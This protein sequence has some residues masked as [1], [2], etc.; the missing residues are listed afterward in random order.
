MGAYLDFA[1]ATMSFPVWFMLFL[2]TPDNGT[3]DYC[4]EPVSNS[5]NLAFDTQMLVLCNNNSVLREWYSVDGETVKIFDLADWGD[6]E[7]G[8]SVMTKFAG[9]Y[10][11][12]M[13][14][15]ILEE[16]TYSLN[17]PLKI[18]SQM[19]EHVMG[20]LVSGRAD[21]AI[22][23]MSMTSFRVRYVDFTLLLIISRNALY[24]KEPGICGVKWLGYFQTF[25]SCTWATIVTLIAIAPL[26]LSYMKTI[27][28][29]GTIIEV[30]FETF[31][32]IWGIFRQ[33]AL[34]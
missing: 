27:R 21:F 13:Y 24:F 10:V 23:D 4:H 8:S 16:L 11:A 30:I 31:I 34:I 6:D 12:S 22:A 15:K 25:N 1:E 19:S 7:N 5:L 18:V 29:S 20:E 9:N 14:G 33:Q 28:E 32:C 2:Y 26:L 17:F 3:H